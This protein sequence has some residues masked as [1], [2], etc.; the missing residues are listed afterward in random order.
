MYVKQIL[1]KKCPL[2]TFAAGVNLVFGDLCVETGRKLKYGC[3]S[4]SFSSPTIDKKIYRYIVVVFVK[5][6]EVK[7]IINFT[8]L[9]ESIQL[10]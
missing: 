9:S 7:L 1:A 8:C 4:R 3:L 10:N 2:S 6:R 5:E